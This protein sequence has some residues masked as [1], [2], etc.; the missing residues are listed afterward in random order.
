MTAALVFSRPATSSAALVFGQPDAWVPNTS[1]QALISAALPPPVLLITAGV[2][3]G[4]VLVAQLPA[5]SLVMVVTVD[6]GVQRPLVAATS[7][8]W[9]P[10]EAVPLHIVAPHALTRPLVAEDRPG[11]DGARHLVRASVLA[12]R[13]AVPLRAAE[14]AVH[15][16]AARLPFR[17]VR[18]WWWNKLAGQRVAVRS[19][20]R[21]AQHLAALQRTA[22]WAD[23]LRNNRPA[24]VSNWAPGVAQRLGRSS[25]NQPAARRMALA[26]SAW[27]QAVRTAYGRSPTVPAL[28]PPPPPCYL[29]VVG[30]AELIFAKLAAGAGGLVF[31]CGLELGSLPLVVVPVRRVYLVINDVDLRR[32]SGDVRIPCTRL[33]LQLDADSWICSFSASVPGAALANLEPEAFG[34]PVELV[35]LVNGAQFRLLAEGLT[36]TRSFG[37]SDLQVTGRGHAAVLDAPYSSVLSFGNPGAARTA[38][39]LVG[40]ALLD[41]GVPLGWTVD[42]RLTDWPVPAGVWSHQG[43]RIS[44]IN[45]IA[46]AA[47]GYLQTAGA[48][49]VLKVLPRYPAAPWE[50]PAMAADLSLPAAVTTR[51]SIEWVNKASYNRVYV[52][53]VGSGGVLGRVTRAGSAGELCAT[54]VTDPL[55]THAAAARQRGMQVLS[56]TGRQAMV[57]LRLPVLPET[58]V[59]QPGT[60]VHYWDAIEQRKGLVRSNA[61]EFSMPSLWQTISVETHEALT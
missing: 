31:S 12:H 50:W 20:M 15:A 57:G 7:S 58:G 46:A 6:K 35:A 29:P 49:Q 42:W 56:D 48:G 61:L 30:E 8:R 52:S 26:A 2:R 55:I 51:E 54:M 19:G 27:H 44:A 5:P 24:V 18:A 47:G 22:S 36:R 21:D 40:D 9:Q 10:A 60:L 38:Q 53:G 16:D 25:A 1:T 39:Q 17:R 11:W 28:P 3:V 34:Q 23:M 4:A 32:V 14:A 33:S 37:R 13:S 59:I 41:N 43:S 45:A